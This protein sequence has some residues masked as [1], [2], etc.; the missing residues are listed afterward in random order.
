MTRLLPYGPSGWLVELPAAD[1][2]DYAAAVRQGAHPAIAEI[3]PAARTVLVRLRDGHEH[4]LDDVGAWLQHL[5][6]TSAANLTPGSEPVVEIPVVY[7]G[8]D[9]EAVAAACGLD[10]DDVIARHT[11]AGYVCAFC[12]FAPGFAY[13]TGLDP[14]LHLPRRSTPRTRVPAG[15][16]AIASDYAAVY[17]SESPGGWH[18]LGRT[19]MQLWDTN[20]EQPATIVPGTAVRFVAVER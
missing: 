4:D 3:V 18:I 13:L 7:D 2:V 15:S 12:G 11:A 14:R 10:V 5:T 1:V 17:P 6:T 8:A 16:V 19:V 20:S 9:L